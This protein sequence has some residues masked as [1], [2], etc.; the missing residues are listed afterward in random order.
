MCPTWS[1]DRHL[2]SIRSHCSGSA[3]C[4][5]LCSKILSFSNQEVLKWAGRDGQSCLPPWPGVRD[6]K[7]REQKILGKVT[8]S[9]VWTVGNWEKILGENSE[10]VA[11]ALALWT[12][13]STEIHSG[14]AEGKKVPG[15]LGFVLGFIMVEA[16]Y[17]SKGKEK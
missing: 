5:L 9:S 3:T 14:S 11:W 16:H 1:W 6:W 15:L 7:W 4:G 12:A 13:L 8:P 2:L 10:C 17:L